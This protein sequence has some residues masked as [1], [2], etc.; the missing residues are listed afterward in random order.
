MDEIFG[1]QMPHSI[2]AEQSVL[3][4]M[5]IDPR[6]ISEA[7]EELRPEDFFMTQNRHIFE[8]IYN[9]FTLS[10]TIDPVTVLN[11]LGV[12]GLAD[13]AGG[14]K[15]FLE[16]M[17]VT[18]TAA[19]IAHYVKIVKDK[20]LLRALGEASGEISDLVISGEGEAEGAIEFAEQKIYNIR[21]NKDHKGIATISSVL[22]DVYE[23][24]GELAKN[25]G[26]IPGM[27][28]GFAGIDMFLSGFNNSDLIL[29]AARP[30]MGKTS[31]ALN[32]AV[33]AAKESDKAIVI[34]SLE[35]SNEQLAL[36]LISSESLVDSKKLRTGMLNEDEWV[37]VAHA[38]GML[39][40]T[41]L[42]LD[43]TSGITVP[44]MKAKC[45]RLG[46]ELGM[47]V[48]DYI[49]LMQTGK[50]SENRVQEVS[51]ISRSLK[52]MAKELD[53]PVLCLSQLSRGPEQR[54][55]NDRRPRLADLR[56]SGA[57][58]Q[59]ADIV[60]FIYRDDYYN[61]DESECPGVAEFTIEKNRHGEVGTVKLHWDSAHTKF[62]DIDDVHSY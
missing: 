12:R 24:L 36:R 56:E 30:G 42:Y 28:S 10:E 38:S 57:I 48:I 17:E 59:D 9:M 26:K 53:V 8:T 62:T 49:Q 11:K 54:T 15:Y 32:F 46:A 18:P 5:L 34:F 52:I 58:E 16:L 14:R 51:E 35:M 25:Q 29:L 45:R 55:G 39:S 43:D 22:M 50:R 61:K 13:A 1:R 44:E 7:V 6:C 27:P 21:N 19:N 23:R 4:A 47:I 3:G 37:S 60:M 41:K 2:E 33:N 20:S 31:A 40:Q